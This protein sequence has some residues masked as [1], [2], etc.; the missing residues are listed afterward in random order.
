MVPLKLAEP[1]WTISPV[2]SVPLKPLTLPV[3]TR[4]SPA[5]PLTIW[6]LLFKIMLIV[7]LAGGVTGMRA[8][9]PGNNVDSGVA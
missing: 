7:M 1:N 6:P 5:T 8:D 3:T 2:S 9:P 4:S